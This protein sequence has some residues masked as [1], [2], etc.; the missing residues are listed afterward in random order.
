MT[1]EL[2]WS[3]AAAGALVFSKRFQDL[4]FGMSYCLSLAR[5][6]ARDHRVGPRGSD[7]RRPRA[8]RARTSPPSAVAW[9]LAGGS[10]RHATLSPRVRS[11]APTAS[12]VRALSRRGASRALSISRSSSTAGSQDA[13]TPAFT[14]ASALFPLSASRGAERMRPLPCPMPRTALRSVLRVPQQPYFRFDTNDYS[15]DPRFAGR[16]MSSRSASARSSPVPWTAAAC[17]HHARS[18]A[19]HLTFTD[20]AH[21]AELDRPAGNRRRGPGGRRRASPTVS[22]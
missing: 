21:Q 6:P 18:F 19:K 3:R 12:C 7:P 15:L 22:L 2:G 5:R 14:A 4:A 16:R 20:P 13:P 8:T 17:A 11:S 1:C 10:S 9:S